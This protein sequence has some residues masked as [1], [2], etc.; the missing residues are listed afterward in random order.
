MTSPRPDLSTAL[1]VGFKKPRKDV[2]E[3]SILDASDPRSVINIVEPSIR[4]AILQIPR[5][6]FSFS[7]KKLRRIAEPDTLAC[8]L[9]YA[10]YTEFLHAQK[11]GIGM[12][13]KKVFGSL[14]SKDTFYDRYLRDPRLLAWIVRPPQNELLALQAIA[15]RAMEELSELI[16][17]ETVIKTTTVD[18]NGDVVTTEKLDS[19]MW[20]VKFKAIQWVVGGAKGFGIQRG[21]PSVVVN[22]ANQNVSQPQTLEPTSLDAI[23]AEMKRIRAL[24]LEAGVVD[25]T[26]EEETP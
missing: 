4:D 18:K 13:M 26:P 2:P 24:E 12:K 3:V 10:W 25:V 8:S 22:N 15:T 17:A 19:K 23:E 5:D 11:M 7:E 9:K 20:D 16:D 14:C 21:S 1:P 6:Y